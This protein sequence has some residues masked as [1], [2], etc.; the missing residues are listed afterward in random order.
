MYK[1]CAYE[2]RAMCFFLLLLAVQ[3]SCTKTAH[4]APAPSS[5]RTYSIT[6]VV[7]PTT[8]PTPTVSVNY[9][10]GIGGVRYWSCIDSANLHVPY[11][12]RDT[13]VY[14]NDTF[15][16]KEMDDTTISRSR[17]STYVETLFYRY[18]DTVAHIRYFEGTHTSGA[19]TD[20]LQVQYDYVHNSIVFRS[21]G[22][23]YGST[24]WGQYDRRIYTTP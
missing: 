3:V 5:V 16:L 10:K 15:E 22:S 24:W 13:V 12:G 1:S 18:S 23:G 14:F 17:S 4:K 8:T 7:T 20:H 11:M 9:T 21:S 2:L 19:W 6:P